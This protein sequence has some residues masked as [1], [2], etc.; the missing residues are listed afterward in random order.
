MQILRVEIR[1]G[2]DFQNEK[3]RVHLSGDNSLRTGLMT[4]VCTKAP[5]SIN[6]QF[7]LLERSKLQARDARLEEKKREAELLAATPVLSKR[8][9]VREQARG[10]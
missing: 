5:K 1:G 2:G 6:R 3:P 9:K 7:T 4:E 10:R 8:R